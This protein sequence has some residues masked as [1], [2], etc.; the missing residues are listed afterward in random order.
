MPFV[1]AKCPQCGGDL[2][3]DN[4]M[5][6][7][8]CMHCGSKIIVHEAIRAVRVDN[9]H[10]IDTWMK[11]GD[12]AAESQNL[13]E[14]YEYYTK[15]VEVQ[16][17]NYWAIYKKGKAAGWQSTLAN[18]RF[19]E[20]AV[21]FAKAIELALENDKEQL[22]KDSTEE[23]KKLSQALITLRADRYIKWPNKDEANGFLGDIN[24]IHNAVTQL[25]NKSGVVVAGY[26]EPVAVLI[27]SAVTAAWTR[28]ILPDY[29]GNENHPSKYAFDQ[30]I[31]RIGYCTMLIEKA[32]D[33]S[34]E[35]DEQ[36]IQRYENL[37][38]IQNEAIK[39][40]SWDYRIS[41]WGKSWHKSYELTDSAKQSRKDLISQ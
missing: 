26:M 16:P 22:K 35:Y 1:A 7:G 3:L 29:V 25:A 12:L 19:T 27:C 20:S 18:V 8:F 37:I 32:I 4:E 30:F 14:A 11:M 33:L 2:Q 24:T 9:T 21:C 17:D 23:I 39:S 36:N 34:A 15:V 13:S 10:M 40:C 5:E 6:T 31:E 28:K 38:F 41:E